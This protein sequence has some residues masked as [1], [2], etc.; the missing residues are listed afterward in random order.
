MERQSLAQDGVWNG[1]VGLDGP[2]TAGGGEGP[3]TR[4]SAFAP[5]RFGEVR[6]ARVHGFVVIVASTGMRRGEACAPRRE[7]INFVQGTVT[8]DESVV[9][10]AGGARI[11]T[12]KS[13]RADGPLLWTG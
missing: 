11:K 12:P 4:G 2:R 7:Y 10:A 1:N 3:D 8:V 6:H 13:V 5:C 9:A